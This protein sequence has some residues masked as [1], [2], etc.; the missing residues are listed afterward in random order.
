MVYWLIIIII[1]MIIIIIIIIIII[2]M[3]VLDETIAPAKTCD[4]AFYSLE[5]QVKTQVFGFLKLRIYNSQMTLLANV[6]QSVLTIK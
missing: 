3:L 1:I 2:F 5:T 4:Q 6:I